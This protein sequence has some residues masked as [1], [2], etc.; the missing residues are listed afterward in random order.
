MSQRERQIEASCPRAASP[1]ATIFLQS[2]PP[3]VALP[4]QHA[5]LLLFSM[6][7]EASAR[8]FLSAVLAQGTRLCASSP[9]TS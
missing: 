4:P 6:I 8:R 5:L 2:P 1:S 7:L 9:P 3:R